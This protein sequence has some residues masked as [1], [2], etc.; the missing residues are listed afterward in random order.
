MASSYLGSQYP[1]L[2]T[3]NLLSQ[4]LRRMYAA[5]SVWVVCFHL[6]FIQSI[7][8]LVTNINVG[9]F[10]DTISNEL[11]LLPQKMVLLFRI[12]G[13]I[14]APFLTVWRFSCCT[15][16]STNNGESRLSTFIRFISSS[17][18]ISKARASKNMN[19][20]TDSLVCLSCFGL[21]CFNMLLIYYV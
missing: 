4:P 9:R 14:P 8:E 20:R 10:H 6:K 7:Q 16:T 15:I 13:F 11:S 1:S 5:V 19:S 18:L 17:C 2:C 3:S 12:F 21:Q